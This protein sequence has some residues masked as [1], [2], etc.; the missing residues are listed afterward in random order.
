MTVRPRPSITTSAASLAS[1]ASGPMRAIRPSRI[2]SDC[3]LLRGR[4]RAVDDPDVVDA[5]AGSVD[6]DEGP[7]VLAERRRALRVGRDR[8]AED[9]TRQRRRGERRS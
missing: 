2:S 1:S 5:D 9:E 7:G 8:H 4:A 6:R 3:P